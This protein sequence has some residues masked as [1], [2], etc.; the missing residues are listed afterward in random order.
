MGAQVVLER[1]RAVF[2]VGVCVVHGGGE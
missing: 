1:L 2:G